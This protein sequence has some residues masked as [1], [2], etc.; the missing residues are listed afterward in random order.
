[1]STF[2]QLV[3]DLPVCLF[4]SIPCMCS[5]TLPI[6]LNLIL[7]FLGDIREQTLSSKDQF[8]LNYINF[9]ILT[10]L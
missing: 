9:L 7:D 4:L 3:L 2:V 10:L 1:M 8:T 5:H 6:K